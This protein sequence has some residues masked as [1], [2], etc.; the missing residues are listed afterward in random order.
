VSEFTLQDLVD[1]RTMSASIAETLR[2]AVREGHSFVVLAIPRLAGKS[3]TLEAMLD[4]RAKGLLARPVTGA[5]AE[6]ETLRQT[7]EGG[8]LVIPEISSG[9]SA[10]SPYIW[11]EPVRRVFTTLASG[12]S[13]ALTLHAPGVAEAFDILS[14]K[15]GIPDDEASLIRLAVYI[16]SIG[17]W[18]NPEKRRVSEVHE[19]V[20]VV[21]GVP[22]VRLLHRW[23]EATD[24]FSDV[25]RPRVIGHGAPASAADG[26]P[27][28]R[29]DGVGG[30]PQAS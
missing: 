28:V 8:Y 6:Q 26:Q 5:L 20:R 13:L 30:Q 21:G 23:D 3:T 19:V 25:D 10:E 24:S 16:Q 4:E 11:G 15:D 14:K 12:Y 27:S 7:H 1:N 9:R 22:E 29:R 17:E 2:T 18:E